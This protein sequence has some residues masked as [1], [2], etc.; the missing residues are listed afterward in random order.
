MPARNRILLAFAVIGAALGMSACSSSTGGTGTAGTA[1]TGVTPSAA[2]TPSSSGV[3]SAAQAR[4]AL[5]TPADVGSGFRAHTLKNGSTPFPCTPN[6]PPLDKQFPPAVDVHGAFL[7]AS[8]PA[9]VTEQIEGYADTGTTESALAAGEKGLGC[10]T[11]TVTING[12]SQRVRISGPTDL[13]SALAAKV[14][15]AEGWQLKLKGVAETIV[16]SRIGPQL[17]VLEFTATAK[18]DQ[19]KLPDAKKVTETALSKVIAAS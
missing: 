3:L 18:T 10:T 17:V 11:G 8:A 5:L 13:T 14:D 19:S 2:G 15:K 12:A 4:R 7:N 6:D 1:A 9:E 16:V